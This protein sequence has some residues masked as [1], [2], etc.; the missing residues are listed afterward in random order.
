MAKTDTSIGCGCMLFAFVMNL[1]V[2]HWSVVY[3]L[4]F[5]LEARAPEWVA[6]LAGFFMGQF[7]V[8]LAIIFW[9]LEKA[10]VAHPLFHLAAS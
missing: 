9:V 3:C 4:W 2:G 5:A 7:T 6:Y 8:P 1:L 10:G